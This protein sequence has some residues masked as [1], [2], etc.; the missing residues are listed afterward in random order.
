MHPLLGAALI[1]G[2]SGI[3][4][5]ILGS[6][7]QAKANAANIALARDQMAWEERMSNT[8]HQREVKDLTAAGLNPLLSV[9]GGASVPVMQAPHVESEGRMLAEGVSAAGAKALEY[10]SLR[11]QIET[12]RQQAKAYSAQA[13]STAEDARGK[14]YRNDVLQMESELEKWKLGERSKSR[15]FELFR[16]DWMRGIDMINP[17]APRGN[18]GIHESPNSR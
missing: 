16:D 9:N 17:F 3:I 5:G 18:F 10:A 2:G 1:T 6:R 14:A 15:K 8:A 7:S 11:Q 12:S 4:G 13:L